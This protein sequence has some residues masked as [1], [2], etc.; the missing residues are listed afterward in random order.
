MPEIILKNEIL[1]A[2][3]GERLSDILIKNGIFVDHPCAGKGTCKKC[4]VLVDG[5]PELSCQYTVTA[6]IEVTIPE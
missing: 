3:K 1:H 5:K 6:D 4:T 2:E